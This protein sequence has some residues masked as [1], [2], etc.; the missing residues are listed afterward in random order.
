MLSNKYTRMGVRH[1][2]FFGMRKETG[3]LWDSLHEFDQKL[4]DGLARDVRMIFSDAMPPRAFPLKKNKAGKWVT[5][6]W[7]CSYCDF[8]EECHGKYEVTYKK[9]QFGSHKPTFIFTGEE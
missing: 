9:D 5:S 3:H 8:V 6:A 4:A 7:Q 2:R 1:V